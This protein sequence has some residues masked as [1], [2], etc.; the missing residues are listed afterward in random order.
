MKSLKRIILLIAVI[1]SLIIAASAYFLYSWV[2]GF[3]LQQSA[4]AQAE[5]VA[6]L[7]SYNMIEL[8]AQGWKR[9]QVLA[10]TNNAMGMLIH[11]QMGIDFHRGD[12]VS[13]LYGSVSQKALDPEQTKAMKTGQPMTIATK[14]GARFIYPLLAQKECLTCHTNA[15]MGNVLGV[16][17]V[18]SHFGN[19]IGESRMI[20]L[21]VLLLLFI[22]IPLVVAWLL[23]LFLDA[24]LLGFSSQLDQALD[25]AEREGGRPDFSGVRPAFRELGDLL[26]RFKR[27]G[28]MP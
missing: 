20:V 14:D 5:T 1:I 6:R 9:D 4:F 26:E 11:G 27:M 2:N 22:P 18:D 13:K 25:R 21:V 19:L 24:R 16:I 15:K 12:L 23:V 10:F 8:M 17:T 3:M 7:T 28:K